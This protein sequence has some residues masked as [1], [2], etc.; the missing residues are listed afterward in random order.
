MYVLAA[1]A[2]SFHKNIFWLH[3]SKSAGFLQN[4]NVSGCDYHIVSGIHHISGEI[5]S[6]I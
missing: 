4:F 5:F 6:K 2:A 1:L 3:V